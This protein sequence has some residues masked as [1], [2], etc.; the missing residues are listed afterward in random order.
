MS[1]WTINHGDKAVAQAE[2]IKWQGTVIDMGL[3]PGWRPYQP[4]GWT[5]RSHESHG[6]LTGRSSLTPLFLFLNF[7]SPR[8]PQYIH[9]GC[10]EYWLI[11][12]STGSIIV[13]ARYNRNS[14]MYFSKG[15]SLTTYFDLVRL[16]LNNMFI[17]KSNSQR[18][19]QCFCLSTKQ[20]YCKSKRLIATLCG[21]IIW[22]SQLVSLDIKRSSVKLM[23]VLRQNSQLFF[24]SWPPS[25]ET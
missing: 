7:M 20:M 12:L 5:C 1:R 21:E 13:V 23:A 6:W 16:K 22:K 11:P 8:V 10:C 15:I 2:Y 24:N 14:I 9:G 17:Q 25:Y 18:V 3:P 19:R 4:G